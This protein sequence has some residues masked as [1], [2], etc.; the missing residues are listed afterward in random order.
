M[1][2]WRIHGNLSVGFFFIRFHLL[3]F[4]SYTFMKVVK[5]GKG[6]KRFPAS[7]LDEWGPHYGG[8]G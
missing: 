8:W 7:L 1:N 5:F 6:M 4:R 3:E 2:A